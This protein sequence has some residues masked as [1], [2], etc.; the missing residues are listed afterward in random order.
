VDL[1]AFG[2]TNDNEVFVATEEP[3][4][5]IEATVSRSEL[6]GAGVDEE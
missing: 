4:G 2:R 3:F 1:S 6:D 5:L